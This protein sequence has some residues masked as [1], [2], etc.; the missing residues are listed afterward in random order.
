MGDER[1]PD[2]PS[3]RGRSLPAGAILT[4]L[5]HGQSESNRA[6]RFAGWDDIDLSEVGRAEAET[7]GRLLRNGGY[8]FDC[9]FTSVLRRATHTAELAL[10]AMG[11]EDIPL[12]R[13]WRLNERHYGA[14]QGLELWPAVR[15]YGLMPVLRCRGFTGRPPLLDTGDPRFPG[16]DP[17]YASLAAG[18]LPRG[19]SLADA[20][21]RVI[22]YW[23]ER[24]VP[25]LERGRRVLVV[26]HKN[27][28]R[29]IV[30]LLERGGDEQ[31]PAVRVL[32][33]VPIV[34]S[35]DAALAIRDR[36]VLQ[37][38]GGRRGGSTAAGR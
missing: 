9:C 30:K 6:R 13:S 10:R 2:S 21:A 26:S 31:M 15:R 7:A 4:L 38:P 11:L 3:A 12:E 25:Q 17:L 33:G 14:L 22:P 16:R 27:T 35:L 5:R 24:I 34:L 8:G 29:V 37:H 36:R 32:T 28:L 20:Q 23:R 18:D 19:E 1:A